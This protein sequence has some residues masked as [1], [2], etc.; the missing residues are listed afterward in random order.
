MTFPFHWQSGPSIAAAV[1][2][3]MITIIFGLIGTWPA[4]GR[5]PAVVLRNL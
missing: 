2:A 4:L 3:V 1:I 5:K